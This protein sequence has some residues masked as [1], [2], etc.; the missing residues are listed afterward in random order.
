M[1]F[2][3]GCSWFLGKQLSATDWQACVQT[4][5]RSITNTFHEPG[6]GLLSDNLL[7]ADNRRTISSFLCTIRSNHLISLSIW[8]LQID[9][10]HVNQCCT[11]WLCSI[12]HFSVIIESSLYL[13]LISLSI[14]KSSTTVQTYQCFLEAL[15]YRTSKNVQMRKK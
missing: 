2:N 5:I 4:I 10:Q 1:K 14:C 8:L 13:H 6:G 7:M 9:C 15:N 11:I 12:I 3:L